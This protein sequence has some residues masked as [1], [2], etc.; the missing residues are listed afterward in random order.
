M[1]TEEKIRQL[2]QRIEELQREIQE[3]NIQ[4]IQLPL[5]PASIQVIARAL[6]DVG[7]VIT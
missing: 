2:E 6:Q 3:R 4:Q 7:Y 1:N 5:D